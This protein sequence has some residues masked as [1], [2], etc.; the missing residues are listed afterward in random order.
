MFFSQ[1][2]GDVDEFH[3]HDFEAA[4]LETM[5][6]LANQAAL[7][8]IGLDHDKCA[9]HVN[10][11]SLFLKDED[12]YLPHFATIPPIIPKFQARPNALR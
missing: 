8:A 1:L 9:F 2:T 3:G 5:D 4:T 12:V 7:H 11:C 10:F 6:N